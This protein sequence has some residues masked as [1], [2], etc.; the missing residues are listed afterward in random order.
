VKLVSVLEE[1]T[2][3]ITPDL[4]RAYRLLANSIT[5]ESDEQLYQAYISFVERNQ[6]IGHLL[7]S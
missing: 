1:G 7:D 5:T 4:R 6:P 3:D 2:L